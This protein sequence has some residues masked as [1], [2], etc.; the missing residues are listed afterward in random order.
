M[1]TEHGFIVSEKVCIGAVTRSNE[2]SR[3]A[4]YTA[5]SIAARP[6]N[7][8]CFSVAKVTAAGVVSVEA[9]IASATAGGVVDVPWWSEE[10]GLE[11]DGCLVGMV[12]VPGITEVACVTRVRGEWDGK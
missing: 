6:R 3:V 10:G 5:A 8:C 11:S 7:R 12:L 2:A 9:A 1:I 4:A